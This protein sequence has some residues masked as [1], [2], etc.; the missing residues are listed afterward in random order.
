MRTKD[1]GIIG[2]AGVIFEF[3]KRGIT[4][5]IPFGD[6]SPYDIIIDV[7]GS[8]YKVQI[9]TSADTNNKVTVFNIKKTR[10]NRK[11]NVVSYYT[12][13]EIDYFVLYSIHFKE[14]Y[15][16]PVEEAPNTSIKI[17]H[18]KA[19][20]NQNMNIRMDVDCTIERVLNI[21]SEQ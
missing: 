10:I 5:S 13:N 2:E 1:Q 16:I 3:E 9:K 12:K 6:N 21:N 20:N 14:A 8:L 7:N 18:D 15:M 4:V 19:K 11:R 17:R